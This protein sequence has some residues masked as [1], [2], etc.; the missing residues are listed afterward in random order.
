MAKKIKD[1]ELAAVIDAICMMWSAQFGTLPLHQQL[2][3][4]PPLVKSMVFAVGRK[5]Q[6][7]ADLG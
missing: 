1:L 4:G 2:K 7:C 5:A 3:K 6:A